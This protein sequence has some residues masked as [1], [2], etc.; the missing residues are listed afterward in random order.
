ME[1]IDLY[2][3]NK[4]KSGGSGVRGVQPGPVDG[5]AIVHFDDWN[6]LYS[7]NSFYILVYYCSAILLQDVTHNNLIHCKF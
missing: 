1:V 3:D 2:F 6:G 5:Q 7:D 4:K